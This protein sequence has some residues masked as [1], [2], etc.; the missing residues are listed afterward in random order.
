MPTYHLGVHKTIGLSS[1]KFMFMIQCIRGDGVATFSIVLIGVTFPLVSWV[2]QME[3]IQF[4]ELCRPFHY[5][6]PWW[7]LSNSMSSDPNENHLKKLCPRE[8]DILT[9]HFVVHKNVGVS[10]SK[11]IF[12]VCS[13][14]RHGIGTLQYFTPPRYLSNCLLSE[15]NGYRMQTLCPLNVHVATF[16]SRVHKIIGISYSIVTFRVHH[17]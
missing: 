9:Y 2:T 3:T 10:Y 11:V 1:S 4:K 8:V 17:S 14:K 12:R 13:N 6:N 5:C 16:H 15:Q 7:N